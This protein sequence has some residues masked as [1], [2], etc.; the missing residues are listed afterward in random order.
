MGDEPSLDAIGVALRVG[1]A[2][3]A[4]GGAYFVGGSL[5]SSLQG[6]PRATNDVDI[7]LQLP[8]GRIDRLVA[9][10]GADFEVD[11]DMLRDALL[12]GRSCNVFY[13]ATVMKV[14]LFAVGPGPFDESEFSRRRPV[15]VRGAET[16]VLKSPEDT[17]LRKLLWYRE[18]GFVSE[19]QWRDVVEVLRVSGAGM[20][21]EYLTGWAGRLKLSELLARARGEAAR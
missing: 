1:A 2:I 5:A 6:E 17:V 19:R 8:I 21:A 14:D 4:A 3:E 12:H 15:V 7:V 20:D 11:G 13:L 16:M 9:T 10:L 18:G